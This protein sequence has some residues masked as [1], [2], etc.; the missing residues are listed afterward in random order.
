MKLQ[1]I[2]ARD[3]RN[4]ERLTY[5]PGP[6]LNI[7]LGNNAQGKTNILESIYLLGTGTSFRTGSDKTLLRYEKQSYALR[8]RY[9]CNERNIEAELSYSLKNGKI[10]KINSKKTTLGNPLRLRV[11]LFS[12]DDLFLIKGSPGKRRQFLDFILTQIKTEY[13]YNLANYVKVLKKRNF[14][15]K[16]EQYNTRSFK[17]IEEVFIENAARIILARVNLINTM[18]EYAASIYQDITNRQGN[19]KIRYALS[20]PLDSGKINHDALRE[21]LKKQIQEKKEQEIK[22]KSSLVGPHRDDL[23]IY[24]DGRIARYFASQGQQRN[25]VVALKLAELHTFRKISGF[26]PV[27]LLDEVLSELDRGKRQLLLDY[28]QEADFQTFLTSVYLDD[29]NYK[30]AVVSKVKDGHLQ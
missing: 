8:G 24:Q 6:G 23:N 7:L 18:D 10:Y 5:H 4:L 28:L 21:A 25:L 29:I 12:P 13:S 11:V 14:L 3:F 16:K 1:Q 15:L 9:L 17:I 20:F 2:E 30:T 22:R 26:N 19:L 27:F